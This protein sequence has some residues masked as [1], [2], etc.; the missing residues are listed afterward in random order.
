MNLKK[1]DMLAIHCYKHNGM[2]YKTWDKALVLDIKENYIVLGNDNVLV[3]KKDGRTWRTREP[4]IMFFYKNMPYYD[5][6]R[7]I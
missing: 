5:R 1:G 6:I 3:T 7:S 2:I 4:A